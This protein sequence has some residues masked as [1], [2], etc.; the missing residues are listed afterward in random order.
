MLVVSWLIHENIEGAGEG[1]CE[2][3]K[4]DSKG[5]LEGRKKEKGGRSGKQGKE[6]GS[7]KK[8]EVRE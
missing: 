8:G 4:Q 2:E 3:T 6:G 5:T 1:D 7:V